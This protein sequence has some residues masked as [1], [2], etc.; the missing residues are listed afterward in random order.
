MRKPPVRGR[1]A[2]GMG[3]AMQGAWLALEA[4]QVIALRLMKLARGGPEAAREA[5]RMVSEKVDATRRAAGMMAAASARGAADG[6][7]GKVVQ[8]L[9]RRVRANR[10]RLL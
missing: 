7:A 8:M 2:K 3:A 1:P 4:Q 9:R 5:E 6:G 10:K